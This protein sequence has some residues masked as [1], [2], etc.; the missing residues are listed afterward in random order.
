MITNPIGTCMPWRWW[1]MFC[2]LFFVAAAIAALGATVSSRAI[3]QTGPP[4]PSATANKIAPWVVE[5]TADG[6]QAEFMV[7]LAE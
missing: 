6:Q 1:R 4:D 7:V 3:G 2:S 5:H